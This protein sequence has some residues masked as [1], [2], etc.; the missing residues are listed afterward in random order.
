MWKRA[1]RRS[2][3][4]RSAMRSRKF[5]SKQHSRPFVPR[6]I[7]H[8]KSGVRPG[9]KAVQENS[10]LTRT[11]RSKFGLLPGAALPNESGNGTQK[12]QEDCS[13]ACRGCRDVTSDAMRHADFCVDAGRVVA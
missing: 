7:A 13:A 6:S 11:K 12:A 10:D 9:A 5:W 8:F 2:S 4:A 3:C 1:E